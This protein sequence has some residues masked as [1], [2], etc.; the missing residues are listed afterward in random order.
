MKPI[1]R[2]FHVL[3][4]TSPVHDLLEPAL[5]YVEFAVPLARCVRVTARVRGGANQ[6]PPKAKAHPGPLCEGRWTGG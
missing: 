6:P 5:V 3:P 4:G 2:I 1:E